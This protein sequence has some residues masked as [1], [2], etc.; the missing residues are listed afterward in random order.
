MKIFRSFKQLFLY[1]TDIKL[2]QNQ[3]TNFGCI[4][5]KAA[6]IVPGKK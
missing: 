6:N 2:T 5:N 1:K 4:F 3:D